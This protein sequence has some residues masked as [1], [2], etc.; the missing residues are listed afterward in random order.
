MKW[1]RRVL[2]WLDGWKYRHGGLRRQL[3]D[4]EAKAAADGW[5]LPKGKL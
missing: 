4:W 3:S 1:L 2:V 5:T